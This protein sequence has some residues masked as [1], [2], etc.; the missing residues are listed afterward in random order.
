MKKHM[1]DLNSLQ[2]VSGQLVVICCETVDGFMCGF[3]L[4]EQPLTTSRV[5]ELESRS[6]SLAEQVTGMMNELCFLCST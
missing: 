6:G 4:E 3:I 2:D 5:P 1:S